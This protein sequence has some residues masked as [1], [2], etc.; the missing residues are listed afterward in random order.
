MLRKMEEAGYLERE[1]R[2][3]GGKVRKYYTATDT[4]REAIEEVREKLRE[5]ASELLEGQTPTFPSSIPTDH[6]EEP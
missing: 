1:D 3:V 6:E 4:G 2:V 5:L